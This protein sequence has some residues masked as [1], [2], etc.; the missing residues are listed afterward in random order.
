MFTAPCARGPAGWRMETLDVM[1]CPPLNN[2]TRSMAFNIVC[3]H[4]RHVTET[5]SVREPVPA[6]TSG[7]SL[8]RSAT[9]IRRNVG[10]LILMRRGIPLDDC[11]GLVG[12]PAGIDDQ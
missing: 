1:C 2:A 4:F 12:V 7:A 3:R 8:R 10:T 5:A 9:L 11:A 6:S